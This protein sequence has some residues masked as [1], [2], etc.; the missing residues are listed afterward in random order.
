VRSSAGIALTI[1]I[2]QAAAVAASAQARVVSAPPEPSLLNITRQ[3]ESAS[4]LGDLRALH[5]GR[6][7]LELRVWSG[8]ALTGGTQAVVLRRADGHWSAYL[9]RVL[10]CE[11]QVPRADF[12]TASRSTVQRYI[13]E[14]RRHCGTTVADVNPGSRLLATDSLI[15][16][17]I[18]AAESTIENAWNAAETAGAADLPPTLPRDSTM[19]DAFMYVVELRRGDEY[20][21]SAIARVDRSDTKA[22][23]AMLAVYAAVNR[24]LPPDQVQK[25]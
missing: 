13:V 5:V 6:G 15:V 9:A 8:Y 20:R 22:D 19:D 3:W 17:P 14:A 18:P 11:I 21:A 24:L 2:A 25:P 7:Y 12:D 23:R 10:R 4:T 1:L 16:E